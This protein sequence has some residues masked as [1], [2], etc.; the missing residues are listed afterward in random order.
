MRMPSC[1]AENHRT[2]LRT[3]RGCI[4]SA[5]TA[6][7]AQCVTI[8]PGIRLAHPP[9]RRCLPA[10]PASPACC[11][12]C[13]PACFLFLLARA[14]FLAAAFFTWPGLP[15]GGVFTPCLS[16]LRFPARP[17]KCPLLSFCPWRPHFSPCQ[18]LLL[19]SAFFRLPFFK[20]QT[21]FPFSSADSSLPF[22]QQQ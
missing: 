4:P 3:W 17:H 1:F 12:C 14:H 13:V 19:F 20:Q 22:Y 9:L 6:P 7:A 10:S 5:F 15:G 8:L 16:C 18:R 11:C 2:L 21:S